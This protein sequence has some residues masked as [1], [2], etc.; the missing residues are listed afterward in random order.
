MNYQI[1]VMS[2]GKPF[3]TKQPYGFRKAVLFPYI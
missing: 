2:S 3:I 1:L